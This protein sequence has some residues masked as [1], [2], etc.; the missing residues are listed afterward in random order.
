MSRILDEHRQLL[1]DETRLRRFEAAL[2]EVVQPH[3]VV[4]DLASGTGI[5]GWLAARAGARRVYA[6]EIGGIIQIAREL[7]R[8]NNLGDRMVFIKDWSRR[9]ELPEQVDLV[10]SDQIGQ[11]GIESDIAQCFADARRRL[12]KPG[13]LLMPS[14]VRLSVAPVTAPDIWSRIDFWKA[15]TLGF[16]LRAAVPTALNSGYPVKLRADQ[17]IG[18]CGTIAT[19]DFVH[20]VADSVKGEATLTVEQPATP[21]GIGGWF[22]AQLSDRVV[23]TNS[24][25][26]SGTIRRR[27][28]VLP[29]DR[30]ADVRP[31][32]SV[33]V[34]MNIV[35]SQVFVRWHVEVT[36]SDG[37][38]LS[39]STHSTWNGMLLSAEDLARMRPDRVVSLTPWGR[40]RRT[41]LD[42]CNGLRTTSEI[43]AEVHA[44]HRE[45]FPSPADA[46]LFVAEVLINYSS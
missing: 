41:V 36:G 26:D 5:L 40:A 25:L 14:S 22:T 46:A 15:P 44:S 35:H 10:V 42:L 34:A 1:S 12:L 30:P 17:V 24:P 6:V 27:N 3:H 33:R 19:F 4:L 16:D 20:G 11:F 7:A 32:D 23:M 2:A 21:H 37:R 45:L 8:A 43:E 9:A 13:G 18:T 29:I 28:V 31:G 38:M 39:S